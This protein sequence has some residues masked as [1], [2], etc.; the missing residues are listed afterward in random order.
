M[1]DRTSENNPQ[2]TD[3]KKIPSPFFKNR[4]KNR[5]KD[6]IPVSQRQVGKNGKVKAANPQ[7]TL[8]V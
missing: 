4:Q 8:S 7:H 5:K 2:R 1:K 6:D 3:D